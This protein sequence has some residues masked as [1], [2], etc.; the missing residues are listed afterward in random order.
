M[1]VNIGCTKLKMVTE[2]HIDKKNAFISLCVCCLL[3]ATLLAGCKAKYITVPVTIVATVTATASATAPVKT[4]PTTTPKLNTM[5]VTL[6]VVAPSD[7]AAYVLP[8]YLTSNTVLHM[9]WK[10]EG[11]PFR[12]TVT[13]PGGKVLPVNAGG[14]GTS[15]AAEQLTY[16]GGF[17]FCMSD[18]AYSGFDW[19]GDGYF[20]FTPN[21]V[22][23]DAP[24]KI[25]LNYYF[26]TKPETTTAATP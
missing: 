25:T 11:G 8:L 13:T 6:A 2:M 7:Y 4:I 9:S 21:L 20:N 3:P 23:G 22:K 14:V 1:S 10:V 19:G 17:A 15:G 5:P 16:S 18:A 12:M 26:D 24:V